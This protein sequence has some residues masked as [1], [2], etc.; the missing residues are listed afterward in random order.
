M[1][2]VYGLL[3]EA[4][5]SWWYHKK[6]RAGGEVEEARK[7][8]RESILSKARALRETM[9][10]GGYFYMGDHGFCLQI[11]DGHTLTGYERSDDLEIFLACKQ[12]GI[13]CIDARNLG[14]RKF[15]TIAFPL[16]AVGDQKPE[17][18]EDGSYGCLSYAPLEFVCA[19]YRDIGAKI[20]NFP[21]QVS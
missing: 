15:E 17:P 21:E 4:A 12:L 5:R 7:R 18:R 19:L 1:K 14:E 3:D 16:V 8:E 10:S 2:S 9:Q 13:T 11:N 20:Y 6:L